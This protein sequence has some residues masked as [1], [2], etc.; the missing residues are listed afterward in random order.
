MI[1]DTADGDDVIYADEVAQNLVKQISIIAGAGADIVVGSPF[2]DFIDSGPGNDTVTG[3][4]GVDSFADA[5]GTDTLIEARDVIQFT[6]GDTQL[7]V[8]LAPARSKSN[9]L[10]GCSSEQRSK[11]TTRH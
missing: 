9:N 6:L 8:A 2:V 10:A 3:G 1:I 4:A 5:G 11:G 7:I